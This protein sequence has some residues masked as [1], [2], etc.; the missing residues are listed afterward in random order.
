MCFQTVFLLWEIFWGNFEKNWWNF[1]PTFWQKWLLNKPTSVTRFGE[2]SQFWGNS[3]EGR[4]NFLPIR[5]IPKMR[6]IWG[7]LRLSI[8]FDF[9]CTKQK[10]FAPDKFFSPNFYCVWKEGFHVQDNSIILI[11][12]FL[13][14]LD[15][16]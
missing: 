2:I 4:G 5:E 10:K 11:I 7:N 12:A 9:Y 1:K 3:W 8:F 6:K 15:V 14:C 13:C 16:F